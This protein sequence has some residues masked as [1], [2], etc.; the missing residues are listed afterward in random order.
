MS[1]ES[2]SRAKDGEYASE[3]ECHLNE[4]TIVIE[5][6]VSRLRTTFQ[7]AVSELAEKFQGQLNKLKAALTLG[8]QETARHVNHF[9]DDHK[10]KRQKTDVVM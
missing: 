8:N 3:R 9:I 1:R 5:V 10:E 2:D 7:V 4:S 6:S